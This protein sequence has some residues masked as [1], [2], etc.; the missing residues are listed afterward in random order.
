MRKTKMFD[1]TIKHKESRHDRVIY[2]IMKWDCGAIPIAEYDIEVMKSS[3]K[4][5]CYCPGNVHH[6]RCKHKAML[7]MWMQR[8][9]IEGL[10]VDMK[11]IV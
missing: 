9:M 5:Y 6:H 7:I 1:Y 8:G 2:T 11:A 4:I 3:G 10:M